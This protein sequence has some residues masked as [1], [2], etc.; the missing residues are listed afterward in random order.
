VKRPPRS[1]SRLLA[2]LCLALFLLLPAAQPAEAIIPVTDYAHMV[3]NLIYHIV[4]YLQFAQQIVNQYTQIKNQVDQIKYQ[5]QS[6]KKLDVRNWREVYDLIAYM[7][8]LMRQ[9]QALAYSM[10]NV[11]ET[12]NDTYP[13]WAAWKAYNDNAATQTRRALDTMGNALRVLHQEYGHD[14]GDQ[15]LL[16]RI[17]AQVDGAKGTQEA[18]EAMAS[19]QTFNAQELSVTKRIAAATANIQAVYFGQEINRRAQAEATFRDTLTNTLSQLPPS[20]QTWTFAP[21][22]ARFGV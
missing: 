16:E 22:W 7:D 15:L 3:L 18:L 5:A 13:G 2:A 12:F 14:I 8:Y 9:G 17:K 20:S 4:H 19:V 21:D 10:D 11:L 6:L 1:R